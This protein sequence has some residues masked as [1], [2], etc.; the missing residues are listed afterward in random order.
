[1]PAPALHRHRTQRSLAPQF[2]ARQPRQT[3][4]VARQSR[5]TVA[6]NRAPCPSRRPN[7]QTAARVPGEA[8]LGTTPR[9]GFLSRAFGCCRGCG[10]PIASG[11]P[12]TRGHVG[13]TASRKG[14]AI[15]SRVF[16]LST[17]DR[18]DASASDAFQ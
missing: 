14:P 5:A 7:A 15:L 9:K 13:N 6:R 3:Y 2:P 16:L 4:R 17:R 12:G 11:F 1:F 18:K 10:T 8:L